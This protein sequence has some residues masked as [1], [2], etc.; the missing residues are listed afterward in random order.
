[1]ARCCNRYKVNFFYNK[2]ILRNS[3]ILSDEYFTEL[4]IFKI[5]PLPPWFR[6]KI[7]ASILMQN[8][9]HMY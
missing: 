7:R 4:K 2:Q 5:Q 9:T 1:M 6:L 3:N 8:E